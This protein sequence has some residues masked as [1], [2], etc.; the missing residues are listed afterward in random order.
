[1][2]VGF[3]LIWLCG[4]ACVCCCGVMLL[5][6]C[7]CWSGLCVCVVVCCVFVVLLWCGACVVLCCCFV[8]VLRMWLFGVVLWLGVVFRCVDVCGVGLC[9]VRCWLVCV[10]CL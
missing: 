6:C 7:L 3:G 10:E 4:C 2:L 9:R 1:M 5:C 8:I